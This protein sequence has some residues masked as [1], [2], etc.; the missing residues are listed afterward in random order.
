LDS[1]LDIQIQEL[2]DSVS[3]LDLNL[4]ELLKQQEQILSG[5]FIKGQKQQKK[6]LLAKIERIKSQIS[7]KIRS[8][9]YYKG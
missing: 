1:G 6:S 2:E 5:K 4:L 7:V 3:Q 9:H 8:Y